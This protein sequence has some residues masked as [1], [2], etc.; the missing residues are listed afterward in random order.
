MISL[1]VAAR[2]LRA[3]LSPPLG[4]PGGPCQVIQRIRNEVSSPELQRKLIQEVS[5][6][7]DLSNPEAAKVYDMDQESGNQLIRRIM[8]GPHAQYRMDLRGIT[9]EDVQRTLETFAKV[10]NDW[11]S[12]KSF[13]YTKHTTALMYGDEIEFTDPKSKLKVVFAMKGKDSAQIITTYWIG[14]RDPKVPSGGCPV[15]GS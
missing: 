10:L 1:R 3:D 12:Q 9:V 14:V 6:G 11:K 7:D 5:K 4:E 15:S 13:Q 2:F 8:I